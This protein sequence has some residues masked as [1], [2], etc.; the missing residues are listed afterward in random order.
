M[1]TES[2][3]E[4]PASPTFSKKETRVPDSITIPLLIT[5]YEPKNIKT[6]REVLVNEIA[7]AVKD[8]LELQMERKIT[9]I[10][11]Y[12]S[13][14]TDNIY[15]NIYMTNLVFYKPSKPNSLYASPHLL[16]SFLRTN[17]MIPNFDSALEIKV[18]PY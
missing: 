16:E 15:K 18:L 11:Q 10:E 3:F 5:S 9:N 2:D 1:N 14:N 13:T 4:C 7:Y 17:L 12:T 8:N 6:I